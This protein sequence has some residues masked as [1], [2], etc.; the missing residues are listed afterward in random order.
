MQQSH[1]VTSASLWTLFPAA[2]AAKPAG[3]HLHKQSAQLCSAVS[4]TDKISLLMLNWCADLH[5]SNNKKE[6]LFWYLSCRHLCIVAASWKRLWNCC[7]IFLICRCTT[8]CT[9]NGDVEKSLFSVI[10]TIWCSALLKQCSSGRDATSFYC[11]DFLT[12][13][14]SNSGKWCFEKAVLTH[15]YKTNNN[16]KT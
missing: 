6:W 4:V 14:F 7:V 15:E 16:N 11:H 8:G 12:S 5:T 1:L 9:R 10:N 2:V 3:C 13:Q